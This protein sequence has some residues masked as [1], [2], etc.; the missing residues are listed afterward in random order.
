[1]KHW[2]NPAL[3]LQVLDLFSTNMLQE[4]EPCLKLF[5][6]ILKDIRI[7]ITSA[8]CLPNERVCCGDAGLRRELPHQ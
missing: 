5:S 4:M 7:T 3:G 1:M 6:Y 2:G 8:F